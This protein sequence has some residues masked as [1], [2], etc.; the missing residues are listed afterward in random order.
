MSIKWMKDLLNVVAALTARPGIYG[1]R[2]TDAIPLTEANAMNEPTIHFSLGVKPIV[3]RTKIGIAANT[4]SVSAAIA[5]C[6]YV[7]MSTDSADVSAFG[8][9]LTVLFLKYSHFTK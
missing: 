5:E 4:K 3:L 9:T 1:K 2:E 8:E 6:V 7:T